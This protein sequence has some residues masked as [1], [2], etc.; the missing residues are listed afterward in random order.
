MSQPTWKLIANLGDVNPVEHGGY[1][2]Y[3]DETG[4]YD[5]EA[6]LLI[7]PDETEIKTD[8]TTPE[9]VYWEQGE[10]TE[11]RFSLERCTYDAANDILSDNKFHPDYPAWFAKPERERVERPQ[12]TTYLQNIANSM[13]IEKAELIR[14]FCSE[15]P[16]ERAE[17]Y[18]CIGEYHGL[19][20]LDSD[21]LTW[22][23]SRKVKERF[24]KEI[25]F[26]KS[27]KTP[28]GAYRETPHKT[29]N[30]ILEIARNRA[31]KGENRHV[32]L[33]DLIDG[34]ELGWQSENHRLIESVLAENQIS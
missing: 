28:V 3:I 14:L 10:W 20:N 16:I 34:Y 27:A 1:F 7:A 11:Y 24:E 31:Q 5:P 6:C 26:S 19:E 18:R 12:D 13:G 30:D 15:N 2:V 23:D 32:I 21:P 33:Q 29:I 4:V 25:Q 9:N 17:A 22:T 8:T